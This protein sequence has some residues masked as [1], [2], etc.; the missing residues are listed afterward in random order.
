MASE[1]SA[2]EKRGS[3]F[4]VD[5]ESEVKK[6]RIQQVMIASLQTEV[7]VNED[8]SEKRV[9]WTPDGYFDDTQL[10]AGILQELQAMKSSRCTRRSP[11]QD[12]LQRKR[13][14]S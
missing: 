6:T 14:G 2:A 9:V 8:A 13:K 11:L 1:P 12:G 3:D 7:E 4:T 10:Q 5:S